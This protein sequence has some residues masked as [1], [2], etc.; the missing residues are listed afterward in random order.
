MKCS[1][2]T[3]RDNCKHICGAVTRKIPKYS[4]D[5]H[6]M[7]RIN[8]ADISVDTEGNQYVFNGV[9]IVKKRVRGIVR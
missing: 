1:E 6:G 7:K 3:K 5:W 2:C 4:N 9:K 8:I